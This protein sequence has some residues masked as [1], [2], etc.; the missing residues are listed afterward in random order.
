[1]TLFNLVPESKQ[2]EIRNKFQ[3]KLE[4]FKKLSHAEQLKLAEEYFFTHYVS[5]I[6]CDKVVDLLNENKIKIEELEDEIQKLANM[7]DRYNDYD[8]TKI[9]TFKNNNESITCKKDLT[10]VKLRI[11]KIWNLH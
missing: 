6:V 1:M 8:I 2:E 7:L 3:P 10:D 9:E 4:E 11:E 5:E